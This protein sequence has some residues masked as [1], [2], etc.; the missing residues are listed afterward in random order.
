MSS[1]DA[2]RNLPRWLV[3]VGRGVWPDVDL[4]ED[5]V[6]RYADEHAVSLEGIDEARAADVYL[7]CACATG[8]PA[9]LDRFTQLFSPDIERIA[10]RV[11]APGVSP[12]DARQLLLDR[13]LVAD[14]R[15][16]AKIVRYRGT[17]SLRNW[18]RA[19][20]ARALIDV[21]RAGGR[22]R[23]VAVPQALFDELAGGSDPELEYMRRHYRAELTSAFEAAVA[24]L[25]PRQRNHLRHVFLERLTLEQVGALYGVHASTVSRRIAAARD[26]LCAA[27][28]E[29]LR[30]RLQVG[31]TE[32]DSVVRLLGSRFDLSL[33]RIFAT[34]SG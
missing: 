27:T 14:E 19:T 29:E 34:G 6:R 16:D 22:G 17:G 1:E 24:S 13:L 26:A 21:Y 8:D 32:V 31:D 25:T 12:E 4:D 30:G 18:V 7:A 23:E 2:A 28:R 20:A 10:A 11:D 5:A 33:H 9:A 15:R 3:E